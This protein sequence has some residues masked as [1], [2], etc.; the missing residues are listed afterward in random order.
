MTLLMGHDCK[1]S[2]GSYRD[3]KNFSSKIIQTVFVGVLSTSGRTKAPK[4]DKT[5]RCCR[6]K[7]SKTWH[8]DAGGQS[9]QDGFPGG[10]CLGS[11][12]SSPFSMVV[13]KLLDATEEQQQQRQ[14]QEQLVNPKI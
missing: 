10:I 12:G 2:Q 8:L 6:L 4:S 11:T 7:T 9:W 1:T 13:F 14:E 5:E 3:A